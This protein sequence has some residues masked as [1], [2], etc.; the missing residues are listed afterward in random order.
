MT[1]NDW[2]KILEKDKQEDWE[3]YARWLLDEKDDQL[4]ARAITEYIIN[5]S[6]R[7]SKLTETYDW[8]ISSHTTDNDVDDIEDEIFKN[9][10][11]RKRV[12]CEHNSIVEAKLALIEA[13]LSANMDYVA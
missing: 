1:Q 4:R 12:F 8:W 7:F 11:N 10:H 2:I 13:W 9:L 6:P 3:W 5:K